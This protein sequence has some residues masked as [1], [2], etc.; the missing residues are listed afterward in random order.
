MSGRLIP[1]NI[2]TPFKWAGNLLAQGIFSPRNAQFPF[3]VDNGT[4][5]LFLRHDA[6]GDMISTVPMLK[7]VKENFPNA[8]IHILCTHANVSFIE[9]CDFIDHIHTTDKS[10]LDSPFRHISTI[11]QLRSL[12]SD[13]IVNC[14]TSKASKNGVLTALLSHNT[15]L[16]SSVYLGDR[17]AKYVSAQSHRASK[18]KTMWEKMFMLGIET[19]GLS[20]ENQ[21]II[22]ILPSLPIHKEAAQQT[23]QSLSISIGAYIA[24]NV[25]VGQERN[26]WSK[27]SY[28]SLLEYLIAKGEQPILFGL[29]KDSH[30]IDALMKQFPTLLHYP[31]DRHI[32][33]IG[34]ALRLASYGLSPDTGFLH[35]ASAARCP[36][37]GLYCYLPEHA[38]DEWAPFGMINRKVI[39]STQYVKDIPLQHVL[40]ACDEL[41]SLIR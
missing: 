17:Y 19:F 35:V 21:A 15:T 12:K 4:R 16:S 14:L 18:M 23:L 33:E 22:P 38:I 24:I 10:I 7:L 3:T 39:S 30:L 13:I 5:I 9:Y 2:F 1:T 26:S 32:L 20:E 41:T 31:Y 37:I 34:E 29:Q 28:A 6:L 25:S 8:E 11:R 40:D 36:M 27:E